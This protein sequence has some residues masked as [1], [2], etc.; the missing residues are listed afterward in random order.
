MKKIL[1]FETYEFTGATRVTH[2]LAKTAKQK[3]EVAFALVGERVREDIESAI[4]K[5]QPDILFSSFILINPDVS[6]HFR[7]YCVPYI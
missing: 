4:I 2:T 7:P 5:E 3:Y 1:F 6:G